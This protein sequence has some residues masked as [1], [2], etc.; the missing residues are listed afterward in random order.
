MK[1]LLQDTNRCKR[2]PEECT[3]EVSVDGMEIRAIDVSCKHST[4]AF[5]PDTKVGPNDE[6]AFQ[7]LRQS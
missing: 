7:G 5:V 4:E 3:R 2:G 1:T 6:M